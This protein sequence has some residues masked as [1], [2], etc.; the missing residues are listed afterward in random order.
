MLQHLLDVG[1]VVLDRGRRVL[2]GLH[3]VADA[4]L[5]SAQTAA[6]S[7]GTAMRVIALSAR[8]FA[9]SASFSA[10]GSFLIAACAL[11]LRFL[12]AHFFSVGKLEQTH[13]HGFCVPPRLAAAVRLKAAGKS[14]VQPPYRLPSAQR[15]R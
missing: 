1:A 7:S 13:G 10:L 14:F 9:A 12:S 8:H 3:A 2:K 6:A 11:R 4:Q 5:Y 15:S